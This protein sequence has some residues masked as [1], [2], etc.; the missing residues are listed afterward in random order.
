MASLAIGRTNGM[1]VYVR[2]KSS[3]VIYAVDAASVEDIRKAP[4]DVPG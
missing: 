3:P 1:L 4:A 2:A